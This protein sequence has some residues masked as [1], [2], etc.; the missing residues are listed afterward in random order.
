[1][2]FSIV[3]EYQLRTRILV[4]FLNSDTKDIILQFVNNPGQCITCYSLY[5][6]SPLFVCLTK[7]LIQATQK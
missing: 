2:I 1:M 4:V 7:N 3:P 5:F 6:L